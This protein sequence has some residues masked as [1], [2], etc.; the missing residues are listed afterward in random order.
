MFLTHQKATKYAPMCAVKKSS[1]TRQI[2]K[3]FYFFCFRLQ[4]DSLQKQIYPYYYLTLFQQQ[5]IITL[6]AKS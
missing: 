3:N 1:R 4:H 6:V 5:L 2:I